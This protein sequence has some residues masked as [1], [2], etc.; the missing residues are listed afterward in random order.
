MVM[1]LLDVTE[2]PA[3][4]VSVKPAAVKVNPV[5]VIPVTPL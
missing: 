5:A 2:I 1:V 3:S 4:E